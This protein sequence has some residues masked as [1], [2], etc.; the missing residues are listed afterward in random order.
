MKFPKSYIKD[1][2]NVHVIIETPYKSRNKFAFDKETNLFKLSKVLPS[3]MEFPCDMGFIPGTKGEDGDPLDALILMDEITYPGCLIECRLLGV[4]KATQKEK[5][6]KQERNDRFI[7][8]PAE[9]NE[10]DHL[11]H[12]HDLNRNKVQAIIDF[13]EN[14]NRNAGKDFLALELLDDMEAHKI[15]RKNNWFIYF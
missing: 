11:Q 7:L 10:Y 9:M 3:G 5:K 14:Y 2:K 12:I 6:G 15:I 8:V 4:I 1:K 13:F